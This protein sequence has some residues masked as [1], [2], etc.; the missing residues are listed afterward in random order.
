MFIDN[1]PPIRNKFLKFLLQYKKINFYIY[2][3]NKTY[4]CINSELYI[5]IVNTFNKYSTFHLLN[6]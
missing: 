6:F 3:L 1:L 4:I 2:N 5:N